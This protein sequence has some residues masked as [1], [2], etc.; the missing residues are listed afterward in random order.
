MSK[1]DWNRAKPY[2]LTECKCRAGTVLPNGKRIPFLPKDDLAKRADRAMREWMRTL[3]PR[4]RRVFA[5]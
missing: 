1:I 2:R 5:R 4:N 3:S